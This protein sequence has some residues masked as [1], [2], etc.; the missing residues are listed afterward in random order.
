MVTGIDRVLAQIDKEELA[1]LA[2]TLGNIDSPPGCEKQVGEFV[3][4]WFK[5][6]GFGTKVLSLMPE[7]PNVVGTLSGSGG[8]YSLLY[9]S[10]MDTG[11]SP[12]DVWM[13]RD[14]MRPI[15][16][17][18]WREGDTLWGYGIVNDKGPMACFLIAAKAIKKAGVTLKGD[19]LLTAVSGE[20]EWEPVD[21][22]QAPQWLSH[23]FGTRFIVT[24]GAIADY[25]LVAEATDF[26]LT[27]VEAGKAI[28]KVTVFGQAPGLYSPYLKR[29]YTLEKD[30][31]AIVRMSKLV[32]RIEDWALQYEKKYRYEWAGGTL[33]PKVCTGA[34][35]GGA[36]YLPGRTPELCSIYVDVRTVPGQDIL[37]I[38]VEIEELLQSLD[39]EGDI[40]LFTSLPGYEAKNIERLADAIQHA[41]NKL[42]NQ[43]PKPIIGPE[44]SMWRDINV[45]N[46]VGIPAATYG[47]AAGAGGGVFFANLDDLYKAAQI[48]AMVALDICNQEKII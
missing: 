33:I 24:H 28:F 47:P 5:G 41:H 26:R 11:P 39:L 4:A 20:I 9:N 7:R 22:F 37:A 15:D 1:D 32:D 38:K 21:E 45:F 40:D 48:Y 31:N 18:A 30:P 25:A 6:E 43:N 44:C 23:E 3:E 14:P 16:H 29:P 42:F 27:W 36:P 8:G 19:L 2:I 13:R 12:H 17:Q 35:R 34:I 10:H 46:E